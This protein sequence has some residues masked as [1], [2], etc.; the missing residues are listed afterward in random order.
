LFEAILK[1]ARYIIDVRKIRK[2]KKPY[3]LTLQAAQSS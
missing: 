1:K 2:N 3:R